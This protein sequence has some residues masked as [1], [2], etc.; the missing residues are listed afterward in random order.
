MNSIVA[1]NMVNFILTFA[2]YIGE[3]SST[4]HRGQETSS[5]L[6]D[7]SINQSIYW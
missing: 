4:A 1:T 3:L 5:P 6:I 2:A 7:K